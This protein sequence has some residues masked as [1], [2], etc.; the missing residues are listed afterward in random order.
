MTTAITRTSPRTIPY[1]L[2]IGRICC[3]DKFIESCGVL[4]G[5]RD[6]V[7]VVVGLVGVGEVGLG[8]GVTIDVDVGV[9]VATGIAVGVGVIRGVNVGVGDGVNVG[10][11]AGEEVAD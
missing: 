3:R 7:G 11:D 6:R 9:G 2:T 1:N 10:V 5:E 4:E 8:E